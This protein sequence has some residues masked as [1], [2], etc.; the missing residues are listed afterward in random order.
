MNL[1]GIARFD[2]A[3]IYLVHDSL[4]NLDCVYAD[5][6]L[7]ANLENSSIPLAEQLSGWVG[8]H[9]TSVWKL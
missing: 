2:S 9:R 1:R 6:A 3:A 8:A 5:G 4:I 7:S